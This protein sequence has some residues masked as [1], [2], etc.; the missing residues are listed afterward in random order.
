MSH[1]ESPVFERQ[2]ALSVVYWVDKG[3]PFGYLDEKRS[4]QDSASCLSFA[5]FPSRKEAWDVDH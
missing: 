2:P 4:V 5:M 1:P 3:Q